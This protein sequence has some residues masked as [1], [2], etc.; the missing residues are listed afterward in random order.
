MGIVPVRVRGSVDANEPLYASVDC[1]GVAVAGGYL[2]YKD[3]K[4]ASLVGYAFQSRHAGNEDE[5][6]ITLFSLYF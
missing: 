6:N 4:D 1:P 2:N 3:I 5:V